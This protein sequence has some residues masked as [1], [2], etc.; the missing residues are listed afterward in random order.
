MKTHYIKI[1]LSQDTINDLKDIQNELSIMCKHIIP[2]RDLHF[3]L[4]VYDVSIMCPEP[5]V[6]TILDDYLESSPLNTIEFENT[7]GQF[8]S[9]IGFVKI[10]N[11]EVLTR[12][13]EGMDKMLNDN[14]IKLM[15]K[16]FNPH[17]T[18][19]RFNP[20]NCDCNKDLKDFQI[21]NVQ[22]SD[23]LSVTIN[24]LGS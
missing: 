5:Y 1:D 3:T 21:K 6:N 4:G 19:Y 20:N 17:V 11:N 13:K 23:I 8:P 16:R 10:K 2:S 12:F 18:I 22:P 24:R 15:D 9:G 14:N 7:L